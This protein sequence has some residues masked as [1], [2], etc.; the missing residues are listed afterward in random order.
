VSAGRLVPDNLSKSS[1]EG[2]AEREG[3][4]GAP[5]LEEPLGLLVM[6]DDN[7]SGDYSLEGR[8]SLGLEQDSSNKLSGTALS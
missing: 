4:E 3:E 1:G 6:V 8:S 2:E 7:G 5:L